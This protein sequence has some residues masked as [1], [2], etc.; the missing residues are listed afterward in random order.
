[1]LKVK[2]LNR[3]VITSYKASFAL[4]Y[5][6]FES[7]KVVFRQTEVIGHIKNQTMKQI[8][9]FTTALLIQL[10]VVASDTTLVLRQTSYSQVFELAKK[11]KKAV[12]LYFHFDGC[13]ACVKMENTAFVDKKVADF[14]NSNFVCFEVNTRKGEGIETN[15]IYSVQL[16][17]TYLFLD[18]NGK[19]LHKIVGV[20]SP[21]EFVLQ[22]Q[23]A[24]SPTKTLSYYKQLY[25]NGKRDADFL[26]DYCYTLRDANEL[27]SLVINEYLNTQITSDLSNEK[28]IKFI[29]EFFIHRGNVCICFNSGAYLYM[30][31]NKDRFA[32]Y[33]DLEQVNTRLMFAVL[34]AVY[35]AIE[36]KDTTEFF[37]AIEA[38][39]VYDIGKEYNFKEM[40]GRITL[41]TTSKT[42][43]LS[44]KISFFEKIGDEKKYNETL[45]QYIKIIWNSAAELNSFSWNVYEQV[46][47]NETQKIKTA[48]KCSIRSIELENNYANNDTYAWL[49]Y[50]SGDKK[51]AL[52]QAIKAIKIAKENNQDFS[53]TQKLIDTIKMN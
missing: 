16:H 2:F 9:T 50:K 47:N 34:S 13:G 24:L 23:K 53:E 40:D 28:N 22:A 46:N 52:K 14:Y 44:A 30:L 38:L 6:I 36:R 48:I 43:V 39:K 45:K 41:W 4:I 17:P 1:M 27:D 26:F 49:L 15:K 37:N 7:Q 18:T 3:Q 21:D 29:Y 5:P 35:N 42:M 19:E 10:S 12:L 31:N 25:Y 33:Y 51:K 20:F 11:E 32:K 8:I